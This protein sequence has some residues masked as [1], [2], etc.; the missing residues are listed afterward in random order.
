[1]LLFVFRQRC[2]PGLNQPTWR[3]A[4]HLGPG[5]ASQKIRTPAK[6]LL[7]HRFPSPQPVLSNLRNPLLPDVVLRCN[8]TRFPSRLKPAGNAIRLVLLAQG[9][10]SFKTS[11]VSR[12]LKAN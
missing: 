9:D 2:R 3:R 11:S 5:V 8:G 6:M 12:K 7:W 4:I 10:L 1:M